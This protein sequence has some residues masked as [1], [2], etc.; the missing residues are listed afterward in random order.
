MVSD[1]KPDCACGEVFSVRPHSAQIIRQ[2]VCSMTYRAIAR[3]LSRLFQSPQGVYTGRCS[4]VSVTHQ[5]LKV[6]VLFAFAT[7]LLHECQSRGGNSFRGNHVAEAFSNDSNHIPHAIID[8]L[9]GAVLH[10]FRIAPC[11]SKQQHTTT[12]LLRSNFASSRCPGEASQTAHDAGWFANLPRFR[13]SGNPAPLARPVDGDG[14]SRRPA[15]R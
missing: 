13:V 11:I 3:Q 8:T 14:T 4:A 2:L 1:T 15:E 6:S 7:A 5:L 12:Q 9:R 10:T